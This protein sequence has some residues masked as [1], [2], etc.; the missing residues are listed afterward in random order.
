MLFGA[1]LFVIVQKF[2]LLGNV[3]GNRSRQIASHT[4]LWIWLAVLFVTYHLNL[5]WIQQLDPFGDNVF[6]L[7][8]V[9]IVYSFSFRLL[10]F[11]FQELWLPIL[12]RNF[13]RFMSQWMNWAMSLDCKF[14]A[15]LDTVIVFCFLSKKLVLM[16]EH[17]VPKI[18]VYFMYLKT[19]SKTIELLLIFKLLQKF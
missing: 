10:M 8:L 9:A 15:C 14:S 5:A 6:S 4:A 18:S 1:M 2:S 19:F 3:V 12:K 13:I 17:F 7:L 16:K 11:V